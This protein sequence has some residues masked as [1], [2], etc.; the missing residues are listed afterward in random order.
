MSKIRLGLSTVF[1]L[2]L[3]GMFSAVAFAAQEQP[4][5]PSSTHPAP[6]IYSADV[7]NDG[8]IGT[9]HTHGNFQN[10]TNSCA[11][12]HSVHN[13]NNDM[14]LMKDGDVELCMSCHDGTMGFYKVT[15]PS[16]AGVFDFDTNGHTSVSMHAVQSEDKKV[17][18]APGSFNNGALDTQVLECSSCH[19]PHGSANDRLLNETVITKA[20]GKANPFAFTTDATTGNKV[21]VPIGTQTIKLDLTNDP[22]FADIN[23]ATGDKGVKITKSTGP[24][25]T[26]IY[27]NQN[28]KYYYSEFCASCHNDYLVS[29]SKPGSRPSNASL[30]EDHLKYAHSGNTGSAGR[31]C[32]SC[33][34]AHGTDERTLMDALG[35]KLADLTNPQGQ[36]KWDTNTAIAYL[37]DLTPGQY[38]SSLKKYTNRAICFACHGGGLSTTIDP[39][40]LVP[41]TSGHSATG[42]NFITKSSIK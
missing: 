23:A 34:Y 20:D 32:A 35:N 28:S 12:C 30:D 27:G 19:N 17:A 31:N 13:G 7:N 24:N 3:F 33:H 10:N 5:V 9:Q 37:K 26:N 2:I 25:S 40:Y 11:N 6:N 4:F 41:D 14:L 18:S 38:G 42:Y 1:M 39:K 15:D 29:R 8:S 22:A 21:P 36:Y 16:G